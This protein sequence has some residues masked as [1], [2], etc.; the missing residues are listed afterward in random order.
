MNVVSEIYDLESRNLR[1][2]AAGTSSA[3]P[4]LHCLRR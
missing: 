2:N 3:G 1:L 4:V